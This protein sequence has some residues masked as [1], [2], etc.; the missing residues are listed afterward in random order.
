MEVVNAVHPRIAAMRKRILETV[1]E[2]FPDRARLVTEV[3]TKNKND[4]FMF[5]KAKALE[6]VLLNMD[7][8][9]APDELI[10]GSYAGKPRGCQVFPEFDLKYVIDEL[11][12]FDDRVA[13]RFFVSE[14]TKTELRAIY[15]EWEG[16]SITDV[17][18]RFFSEEQ[19]A[20]AG[21][22]IYALT[23]LRSGI[24]HVIV[25]YE[26]CLKKGILGILEEVKYHKEQLR[27]DD[28]DYV[29]KL[30]YFLATEIVLRAAIAFA[31]RFAAL[32]E[33]L[34]TLENN[35]HRRAELQN[36]AKNC[37]RV[38]A[39][40]AND[41]Y[42]ALQSFWFLHLIIHLE[43][44]GHSISPGR[45]DQ[46]MYPYFSNN[47]QPKQFCEELMQALW[48]KFFELNKVRDRVMSVAFGGYP[49]FQNLMAGGQDEHGRNAV[50]ELSHLVLETTRKIGLPQP[51]ISIRW[52]YDCPKDFLDHALKVVAHGYG[53]P[54]MFN[55]EV[56]IP[57]M[58]QMGYSLRE[59]RD[60]AIVGC[61]ETTGQG[62]NQPWLTGGFFN[63]LKVLELTL[64]DGYDVLLG[65]QYPFRT[66]AVETMS[67][68]ELFE[69]YLTQLA[70]YVDK[71]IASDN[72]LDKL[73]GKLFP[74]PFQ[75]VF[76]HDCIENGKTSL[77]GGAR[78]NSTTLQM[79]GIPNTIDSLLA[80]RRSIYEEKTLTWVQLKK[81]LEDDFENAEDIRCM[82]VNMPKYGMDDD[83]VDT[84]G[85]RIVDF[86][87]EKISSYLS[88][89]GSYQMAIYS[90]ASH[91]MFGSK[92][93]ATADGR[94]K[95]QALADGGVSCS[96]G[97]DREGLTALLN[98]VVKLD[99]YK[100]RGSTLLNV[101]LSPSLLEGEY[102]EKTSSIIR[103][104]FLKKGQHVQFNVVD[105]KTLVDAQ[106]NPEK[107]PMLT[108]RVAGFSVLFTTIDPLLQE[109]IIART[110]H[111]MEG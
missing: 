59:A 14:K 3:Y 110:E 99:P 33:E 69:A 12:T 79:V 2:I 111:G 84:L 78:Y 39:Y 8:C 18:F 77:T 30:D 54:A 73:H 75:S 15:K 26:M 11:D 1:P 44:N 41:F 94:R 92:T 87:E 100:A 27:L 28:T 83:S 89:R 13:D 63:T 31:G 36:I 62:N 46:Y 58:L 55:D 74:A 91:I 109:D 64:Y 4:T 101:R 17:A 16:N 82:L 49:M 98:S 29:D 97:S 19:K 47:K 90:I 107:Y 50:N 70:F 66:G 61:T 53:M 6:N 96:H 38:P 60:Y 52:F 25:D 105:T 67:F 80:I 88:P 20:Y 108:V 7:I 65:K 102:F 48:L 95:Y 57:N 76:I 93:G 42:E 103:T 37:R 21:D 34:S 85:S 71:M 35:I 22:L 72:I 106:K 81:A 5:R 68:E 10:A 23:S 9:I 40:P 32:A 104:Y 51:S 86:L 43:D 56:L 45:F 24:G